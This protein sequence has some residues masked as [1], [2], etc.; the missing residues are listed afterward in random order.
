M[1]DLKR[2]VGDPVQTYYRRTES[3]R[4]LHS[5]WSLR[6][7]AH[8]ILATAGSNAATIYVL[9]LIMGAPS[10]GFLMSLPILALGALIN[11][12]VWYPRAK[13][14]S[15]HRALGDLV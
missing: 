14:K 8:F 10:S 7:H 15:Q 4:R 11:G 9:L 6:S 13:A 12:W 1:N 5:R 2:A 3:A